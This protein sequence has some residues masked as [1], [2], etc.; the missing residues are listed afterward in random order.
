MSAKV[1]KKVCLRCNVEFEQELLRGRPRLYCTVK[2][3]MSQDRERNAEFKRNRHRG[4][5]AAGVPPSQAQK[6]SCAKHLYDELMKG[7]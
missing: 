4:L 6:A 5:R 3:R 7:T 1:V 2:C